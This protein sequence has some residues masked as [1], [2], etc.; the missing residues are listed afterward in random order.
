MNLEKY[1]INVEFDLFILPHEEETTVID[2][3]TTCSFVNDVIEISWG[4]LNENLNKIL[5]SFEKDS[6][7]PFS[8]NT[9]K[10]FETFNGEPSLVDETSL[11]DLNS[12]YL[13]FFQQ[14][15]QKILSI[16]KKD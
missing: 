16:S 6:T 3:S 5:T 1:K 14:I 4:K 8:L 12:V 9:E 2:E 13:L 15:L 10:C 7:Q 11:A